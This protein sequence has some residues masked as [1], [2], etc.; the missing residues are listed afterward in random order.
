[1]LWHHE[2]NTTE[3]EVVGGRASSPVSA[4]QG[5]IVFTPGEERCNLRRTLR[6]RYEKRMLRK[7]L[8]LRPYAFGV[9][10]GKSTASERALHVNGKKRFSAIPYMSLESTREPEAVRLA[11]EAYFFGVK[12]VYFVLG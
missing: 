10:L 11:Q 6:A 8:S 9:K 7:W 3:T 4:S 1:V 2:R 12:R 5:R